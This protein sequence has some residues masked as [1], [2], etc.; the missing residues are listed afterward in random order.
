MRRRKPFGTKAKALL[1]KIT[2]HL[3]IH[4]PAGQARGRVILTK[5]PLLNGLQLNARCGKIYSKNWGLF[6]TTL[7]FTRSSAVS[8]K[9]LTTLAF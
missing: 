8:L 7:K 1:Q 2:A 4:T 3:K 9:S 5:R 6:Q